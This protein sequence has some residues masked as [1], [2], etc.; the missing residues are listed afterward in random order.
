MDRLDS[1]DQYRFLGVQYK[2][3]WVIS[4]ESRAVETSVQVFLM[5]WILLICIGDGRQSPSFECLID[6]CCV[7]YLMDL[8]NSIGTYLYHKGNGISVYVLY[9]LPRKNT[10]RGA[11][12]NHHTDTARIFY[13]VKGAMIRFKTENKVHK[14][15]PINR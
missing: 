6:E 9:I 10:R 15:S 4:M 13:S 3:N 12:R 1:P 5:P 2:S 7:V 8:R 11:T 14:G